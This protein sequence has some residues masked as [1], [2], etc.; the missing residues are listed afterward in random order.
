MIPRIWR[1]AAAASKLRSTGCTCTDRSWHPC[2]GCVSRTGLDHRNC[3][4]WGPG[5]R[6][7]APMASIVLATTDQH[8]AAVRRL[9][10]AYRRAVLTFAS[11]AEV[12]A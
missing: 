2:P 7:G 5:R 11:D 6:Y 1:S 9:F 10:G 8:V 4:V 12:C 3:V